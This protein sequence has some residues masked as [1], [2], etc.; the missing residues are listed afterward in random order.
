MASGIRGIDGVY[1]AAPI[2]GILVWNSH[3]F[4]VNDEDAEFRMW[5]NL[6]FAKKEEQIHPLFGIID[7]SRIGDAGAPAFGTNIV[8]QRYVLPENVSLLELS[9]HVHKRGKR[10]RIFRGEFICAGGAN[11]GATCSPLPPD[12]DFPV[13]DLCQGAPCLARRVPEGGDCNGDVRVS[14][15]EVVTAVNIALGY[16]PIHQ[17]LRIDRDRNVAVSID[18]LLT[19]V[20]AMMNPGSLDPEEAL[21]YTSLTYADPFV[22]S[23]DP[24][25]EIPGPSP[26]EERT[27][28]Y[29]AEYDNGFTDPS[30]VK[31]A[32]MVPDNGAACNPTHCV[33]GRVGEPCGGSF[34]AQRDQSCDDPPGS[35]NGF[36]DA[37]AV[38]FGVSTDD[39]MIVL[40]GSFIER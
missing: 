36:C 1:A 6:E 21:L 39:E 31:R 3:A 20:E 12:P 38:R 9:S 10:F 22:L 25:L 32:S 8:C 18:E 37:C 40:T 15:D 30:T 33:E 11:Y 29:C 17:C 26:P 4:N 5:M 19:A 2:K 14:I 28:T 23:L 13:P 35:G 34:P 27:L 7:T 24:P 16:V